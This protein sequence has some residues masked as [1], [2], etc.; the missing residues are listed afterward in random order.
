MNK[1]KPPSSVWEAMAL[2]SGLGFTIAIPLAAG[3]LLGIYLDG[4]T[5]HEPLF[6]LL[7]LL[8]GLIVG[9]YGAYRLLARFF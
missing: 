1:K 4:R 8:L 9:I 5:N 2:V 7:G 3:S 6:L